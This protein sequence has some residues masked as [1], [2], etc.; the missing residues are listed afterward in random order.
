MREF[1]VCFVLGGA[2]Y[3]HRNHLKE[4]LV[5]LEGKD[6]FQRSVLA[7]I[8]TKLFMASF[9]ALGII[10][11]LVTGPVYQKIEEEGHI[12]ELNQILLELKVLFE[13]CAKDASALMDGEVLLSSVQIC[14]DDI[15]EELF[16]ET[17]DVELDTLTQ[18]CLEIICCNWNCPA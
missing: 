11:K 17:N 15:C 10:N 6:F 16:R 8:E 3:F 18:E 4:L 5:A 7:D 13:R 2:V 14:K 1:T 12:F 9:R